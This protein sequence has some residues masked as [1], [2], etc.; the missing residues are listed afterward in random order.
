[1][2]R[3]NAV[4]ILFS[5]VL[6]FFLIFRV[7][8]FFYSIKFFLSPIF[9]LY[10][11]WIILLLFAMYKLQSTLHFERA[12]IMRPPP[13]SSSHHFQRHWLFSME[14]L[15]KC[16]RIQGDNYFNET[17]RM[18]EWM[19]ISRGCRWIFNQQIT[20]FYTEIPFECVKVY[21]LSAFYL[22]RKRFVENGRRR[23]G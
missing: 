6:Y 20:H 8:I 14:T 15:F 22:K 23:K 16:A 2:K 13:S 10:K 7:G 9:F 1:M 17:N 4:S 18:N 3:Y 19:K 21:Y 12:N 5:C 11:L